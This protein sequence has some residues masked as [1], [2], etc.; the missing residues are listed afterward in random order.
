MAAVSLRP[1]AQSDLFRT[2]VVDGPLALRMARL[3]AAREGAVGCQIV[4]LSQ[5]AARLAGGFVRPA[6][7]EELEPALA[8]ALAEG[9]FAELTPLQSLPG[10]VRALARTF[11][12][13]WSAGFNLASA[14]PAPRLSD[15]ALIESRIK[16][17][18]GPGVLT[19]PD[20]AAAAIARIRL[21][22]DLL[23]PVTL[24][25]IIWIP[26][27][28][29]SLLAALGEV[30]SV[31][32]LPCE[33]PP[34][35]PTALTAWVCADPHAEVVEALRWAR[36]LIAS[37]T[38]RP[39]EI[40]IATAAPGPWDESMQ[41]L[42]AS[43]ELPVHFSHGTPILSTVDGQACAAL[44]ELL[45]QGL[46]QERVRRWLAHSMR[47]C[48]ALEALP[49]NPLAGV[50]GHVHLNGFVHWRRALNLAQA[51]RTDGA[52][53]ALLLL[54]ALELICRGWA[55][56]EEAGRRLLPAAAAR[57][58]SA[59][60]RTGPAEALAFSLATLRTPDG[61]DPGNSI[62]WCP[63]AHLA[64]A[65]RRFVR[66][67]GL[68][69]GGWPRGVSADP[70][71][72]DHILS[73]DDDQAPTR[74][75]TDRRVFSSI[76]RCA[77]NLSFSY[78]R[79][80][81]RGGL[82]T[83]SPL[84]PAHLTPVRLAR[85]RI[86]EHAFSTA[87]RL[88]ARAGEARQNPRIARAI[89]CWLARRSAEVGAH[90]GIIQADHPVVIRALQ[91]PQSATSLRRLLRD[92][93]GF[94]WRYALGW[95]ET[96]VTDPAFDLDPRAFGD[97]VH[98]LLQRTVN[99]LEQG[100]GFGRASADE[101]E[102]ALSTAGA[103]VLVEWPLER[104]APPPLLWRYTLDQAR[105][106]ALRAL[107][108]DPSFEAGTRSWTEVRFGDPDGIEADPN[109]PWDPREIVPVP[110]V[111]L[112]IRGAIDRLE[113]DTG[114]RRARVTDYKT[115]AV[116]KAPNDLRLGGGTE[117]QRVLY[118]VAVAHH[119]PETRIQTRLVFLAEENPQPYPLRGEDLD[120]AL[121]DAVQHLKAGVTLI[122]AG[123]S[124]PGPHDP[125][126]DWN[127]LRIALPAI[128]EPFT[129][130]KDA[131]F[132]RAFGDFGAVWGAR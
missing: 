105:T 83:H 49:D 78:S 89:G 129:R 101:V 59:A 104:P 68:T 115:G 14:A 54:P 58:W 107:Q 121:A 34:G 76:A 128:G 86:P 77:E 130:I 55:A 39:E 79:R 50:P 28:W 1:Q 70:L 44:A 74:S 15:L 60:M 95:R 62:A 126:E 67:I 65:P 81:A 118:A 90:D 91:Q 61:A 116:P 131:A 35:A 10:T 71:L 43:A 29:R 47:R 52:R 108:L 122:R 117:L 7:R 100:P 75:Q 11:E 18:L 132:R 19:P 110:G 3:K 96:V 109:A 23:G 6:Q 102:A 45:G 106:V 13:L 51:Q 69:A 103:A 17:R 37:G 53:P 27:V 42:V 12:R 9:R 46:S 25:H 66:L 30:T 73:L 21:A 125:W 94:V 63:A 24:Q 123:T 16:A 111:Q 64:G 88:A 8:D 114:D 97:L 36:E 57:V 92:P 119:R 31:T 82:Q 124:L 85:Q 93:Q 20:L 80:N 56:A 99:V 4:S 113:L 120:Q 84:L 40:A 127:D 2:V 98:R 112:A 72:P 32:G 87:D 41:T 26:P 33:E 22:T 38:A 5:L 48:T